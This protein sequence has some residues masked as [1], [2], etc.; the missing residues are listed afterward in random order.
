MATRNLPR[1]GYGTLIGEVKAFE[2][3][4]APAEERTAPYVT[5][6]V[7]SARHIRT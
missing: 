5:L 7:M 6:R 1:Q 4:A 3:H 2:S